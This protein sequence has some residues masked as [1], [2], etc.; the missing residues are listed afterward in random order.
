MKCPRYRFTVLIVLFA[1]YGVPASLAAEPGAGWHHAGPFAYQDGII[2][3]DRDQWTEGG[4]NMHLSLMSVYQNIVDGGL[5]SK[6]VISASYDFQLYLDTDKIGFWKNGHFLIRAEGK[7]DD[8]GVNLST[9]AIIPVNFDAMVPQK[10]GTA[11]E[12]T[13]WYYT[14]MFADGKVE[15]LVGTWDV[16]RFLDLVPPSAPYNY[17]HMNVNMYWNNVMLQF[18]PYHAL[19]GLVI[20]QPNPGLTITTGVADPNSESVDVDWY[21]EG[22]FSLYHEWRW[23]ARPFGKPSLFAIGGAYKDKEQA[24]LQQDPA[25]APV[26]TKDDDWAVYANF[27]TWLV[28]SM[29]E[30]RN[31]GLYGRLGFSNGDI[32]P[33]KRHISAGIAFDGMF[34]SR[35][36]D[37]IGFVA[38]HDEF[39]SDLGVPDDSSWGFELHYRFQVTPWLQ[40]TPD[41][42]YLKDPGPASGADDTT[43]VGLRALFHF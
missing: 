22:D 35:P 43:V 15:V 16:A 26:R 13:E 38:W 36:R 29:M 25:P 8:T 24:T 33:I 6:D 2:P 40:L 42:Q 1:L 3:Y 31:V 27:T 11:L 28:G 7:T 20:L 5:E 19:G 39:S 4:V 34:E 32:N 17:R 30:P 21:E 10:D 14:H 12:L 37:S 18:A 9:G 41:I 23:M